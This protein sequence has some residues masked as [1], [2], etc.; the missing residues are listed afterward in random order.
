MFK[1]QQSINVSAFVIYH[2]LSLKTKCQ[3][4]KQRGKRTHPPF[5]YIFSGIWAG[6]NRTTLQCVNPFMCLISGIE[7]ALRALISSA[8]E[9]FG[10]MRCMKTTSWWHYGMMWSDPIKHQAFPA[11]RQCSVMLRELVELSYSWLKIGSRVNICSFA[12]WFN[13][14]S[15]S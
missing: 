11:L 10:W 14:C 15:L 7:S 8:S 13:L 4:K 12:Y 1:S 5:A 6:C 3:E 9:K 2:H